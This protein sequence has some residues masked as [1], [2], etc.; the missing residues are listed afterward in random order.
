MELKNW[1]KSKTIWM[2]IIEVAIGVLVFISGQLEIGGVITAKGII[3]IILR[4]ITK[5]AIGK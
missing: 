4:N 2:G 3:D 5:V 1:F